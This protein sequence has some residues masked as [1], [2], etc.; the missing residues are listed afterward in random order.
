M[1]PIRKTTKSVNSFTYGK[2]SSGGRG[3]AVAVGV[4]VVS[5]AVAGVWQMFDAGEYVK[6][7]DK[8]SGIEVSKSSA[9]SENTSAEGSESASEEVKSYGR[10]EKGEWV[11]KTYFDDAVFLGDS[12][13]EGI[14]LY[15]VMSNA[16]ILSNTGIGLGNIF[17]KEVDALGKQ[18][19]LIDALGTTNAGKVYILMGANSM[20]DNKESFIDDYRKLV[21]A[22]KQKA[23]N[24]II[25]VQSILPVTQTYAKAKPTFANSRI[26]EFNV[27]LEEMCNELK[28]YYIH[29]ADVMKDKD[30]GLFENYSADGIHFG[31][32]LYKEWFGYLHEHAVPDGS[33][34]SESSASGSSTQG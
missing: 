13:T 33:E 21:E 19:T 16:T 5:A 2:K 3:I 20:A 4:V 10:V 27:A 28:V 11:R 32:T 24:A 22:V 34:V 30:G 26:D 25:Y 23:P 17:T 6:P 18:Q 14:K 9:S 7:A 8:H 29:V 1:R 12:I 15:D 31:P